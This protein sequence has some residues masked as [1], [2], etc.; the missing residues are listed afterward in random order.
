MNI[1]DSDGNLSR[2][3]Y[4]FLR[5]NQLMNKLETKLSEQDEKI[6]Q[7][8]NRQFKEFKTSL[9]NGSNKASSQLGNIMSLFGFDRRYCA[10]SGLPIIGKFFKINGRTVS[11]E[12][13]DSWKLVQEMQKIEEIEHQIHTPKTSDNKNLKQ[14]SNKGD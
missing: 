13:Y 2:E 4:V 5:K 9:E 12:A 7:E 11:K 10:I 14:K 1:L 8:F 6:Y 3:L